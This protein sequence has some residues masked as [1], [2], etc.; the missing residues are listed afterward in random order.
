MT[1]GELLKS[2]EHRLADV[3]IGSARLDSLILL[4][5]ELSRDRSWILAHLEVELDGKDVSNLDKKLARRAKHIPLAYIRGFSEFYGRRILVN[6]SV[7]EPRPESETMIEL[8]KKLKLPAKP[9]IADI[10][11]GSGALAIIA[12]LELPKAGVLAVDIDPKCLTVA[13]RN[14]NNLK[15]KV[16]FYRGDLLSA[17]PENLK[18]NAILANLPYVPRNLH[19]NQAAAMEPRLAIDGGSD[20]LDVYRRFFEQVKA[21]KREPE[22]ILAESLPPQHQALSQI[23]NQA[24]YKLADTEDLIQLFS[25][26]KS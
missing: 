13:R 5:D 1:L 6:A 15:A 14:A 16:R 3:D 23:A 18:V 10:G 2:A 26:V 22:F 24:G 12:K 17:L 25:R 20:G 9:V 7:L 19:I 21:L 8:L 11:T 4:E